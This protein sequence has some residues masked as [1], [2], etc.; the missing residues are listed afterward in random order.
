MG[1]RGVFGFKINDKYKLAYN[2][3][4]SYIEGLGYAIVK[5]IQDLKKVNKLDKL[6]QNVL[7]L[8]MIDSDSM[9]NPIP[10]ELIQKYHQFANFNVGG[11]SDKI[12]WYQLTREAQCAGLIPAIMDGL[13][14]IEDSY[15]FVLDSLFCEWGYIIDFD[16]DTFK[17]YKGFQTK[18]FKNNEF[19][20]KS[21]N[22]GSGSKYYPI[23]LIFETPLST[24]KLDKLVKF[25]SILKIEDED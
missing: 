7:K 19:G 20:S 5:Q 16:S 11:S 14:H 13:E 22:S 2:H 15:H 8:N 4:D 10:E 6:K 3:Y 23:K 18:K 1:T 21:L 12:T 25:N 17:V 9:D 24:L